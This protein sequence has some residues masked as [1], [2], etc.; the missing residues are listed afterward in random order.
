MH[1]LFF[2]ANSTPICRNSGLPGWG[3]T[4]PTLSTLLGS[5]KKFKEK[6]NIF[7]SFTF[8]YIYSLSRYDMFASLFVRYIYKM[9]L[10]PLGSTLCRD[11]QWGWGPKAYYPKGSRGTQEGQITS[12]YQYHRVCLDMYYKLCLQ[13]MCVCV[14][15]RFEDVILLGTVSWFIFYMIIHW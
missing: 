3:P 5:D 10:T 9:S 2:P 4:L 6:W 11:S 15:V 14:C 8:A 7:L 13:D 1:K 12:D